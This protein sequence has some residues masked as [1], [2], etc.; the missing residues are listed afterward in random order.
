MLLHGLTASPKQFAAF[1]RMLFECGH[2]VLIPCLPHH[3]RRDRMTTALARL[4]ADELK[5][6]A[7][8]ALSGARNLGENV[9]VLGFSTGGTVAL[10]LAQTQPVSHVVAVAP[11][12]GSMWIPR[13]LSGL[14]MRLALR[15]PNVFLWWD[16]IKRERLMPEHGYPRYPTHGAAQAYAL[17]HELLRAPAPPAAERVTLVV[18]ASENTVNNAAI[19]DLYRAWRGNGA[20]GVALVTLAGLRSSHDVIEPERR[21]APAELVY[22]RLLE[23]LCVPQGRDEPAKKG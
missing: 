10:W 19:G 14:V 1:G 18:N 21:N 5:T 12:L 23:L 11:F 6:S 2:N 16:P 9:S 3:G 8:E 17:G 4:T 20:E 22:P 15:L 13:R 7:L